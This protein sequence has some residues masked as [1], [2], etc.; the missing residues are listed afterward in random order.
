MT[1]SIKTNVA[2]YFSL[3]IF[4]CSISAKNQHRDRDERMLLEMLD[5]WE[6]L[7]SNSIDINRDGQ[8]DLIFLLT[9]TKVILLLVAEKMQYGNSW[10]FVVLDSMSAEKV[11]VYIL[12]HT[13]FKSYKNVAIAILKDGIAYGPSGS[14]DFFDRFQWDDKLQ[15]YRKY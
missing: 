12:K 11:T 13:A 9:D 14:D 10:R 6:M 5:G 7:D 15:N 2:I 8:R 1:K 4:S 3:I